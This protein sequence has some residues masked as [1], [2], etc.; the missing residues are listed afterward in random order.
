MLKRT[1][2]MPAAFLPALDAALDRLMGQ[3]ERGEVPE[4]AQDNL[5]GNLTIT[6]RIER[7][8]PAHAA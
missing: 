4:F 7:A 3:I 5:P 2:A 8:T 6:I 1:L